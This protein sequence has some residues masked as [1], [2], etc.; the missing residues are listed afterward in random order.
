MYSSTSKLL[1]LILSL[2][3]AFYV[4]NE[5]EPAKTAST[6]SMCINQRVALFF[7]HKHDTKWHQHQSRSEHH[8]FSDVIWVFAQ[9]GTC[10]VGSVLTVGSSPSSVDMG[11]S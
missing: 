4:S 2:L 6:R 10:G 11:T 3:A 9:R 8:S 7:F 5:L 1:L